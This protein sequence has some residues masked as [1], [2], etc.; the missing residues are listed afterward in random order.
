MGKAPGAHGIC[1]GG[2]GESPV[3]LREVIG[4]NPKEMPKYYFP[5][6]CIS[7]MS[8]DQHIKSL[9]KSNEWKAT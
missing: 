6:P 3:T 2:W 9:E 5:L 4:V 8:L 7:D 1:G